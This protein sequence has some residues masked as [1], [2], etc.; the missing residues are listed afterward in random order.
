[1]ESWATVLDAP[2][3][4]NAEFDGARWYSLKELPSVTGS[5]DM[6]VIDGPPQSTARL[7][8]LPALPALAHMTSRDCVVFLDDSDRPPEKES[9]SPNSHCCITCA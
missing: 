1:M 7:A 5:V 2:L 4:P 8:R 9:A 3:E 6:L